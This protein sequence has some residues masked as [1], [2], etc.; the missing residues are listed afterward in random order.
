MTIYNN[1]SIF[2]LG[3][4]TNRMMHS[5]ELKQSN[6][7][8]RPSRHLQPDDRNIV[9]VCININSNII[10]PWTEAFLVKN[11]HAVIVL[12]DDDAE[13]QDEPYETIDLTGEREV[14]WMTVGI[15]NKEFNLP[16]YAIAEYNRPRNILKPGTRIIARFQKK[17][18]PYLKLSG[19]IE[20]LVKDIDGFYSGIISHTK[21]D[22]SYMVF[23]DN[24]LTQYVPETEIRRVYGDRGHK[25]GVHSNA[26]E[27]YNYYFNNWKLQSLP[28]ITPTE[29]LSLWAYLAAKECWRMAKVV[30]IDEKRPL[31]VKLYFPI[32]DFFEWL[33]VGS[34]R[35]KAIGKFINTSKPLEK[36]N[37]NVSTVE[38]SSDSEDE[39]DVWHP[40]EQQKL[41]THRIAIQIKTIRMKISP[42]VSST[43][44][45]RHSCSSECIGDEINSEI[46]N[47]LPKTEPLYRPL[48]CGWLRDIRKSI[49]SSSSIIYS[50]PCGRKLMSIKSLYEHLKKT[51]SKLSIDC[52]TFEK[53]VDCTIIRKTVCED[54]GPV[55]F[56]NDVSNFI[57]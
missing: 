8:L 33:Y 6:G 21:H 43:R 2:L 22:S 47:L 26:Q 56:L 55:H 35:I 13:Q 27:F 50:A 4:K 49:N 29:G 12:D 18:L 30:E 20:Y 46:I 54:G 34:P 39:S 19:K 5:N 23:F 57:I 11:H 48:I 36:Y 44:T 37:P 52:F 14:E 7:H 10:E 16:E 15:D 42:S 25:K 32:E 38:L 9:Y 31:M 3:P 51:R 40:R 45:L 17:C 41:T 28:E 1:N 53:N 24:G